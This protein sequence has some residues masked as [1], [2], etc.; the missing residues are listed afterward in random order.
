MATLVHSSGT[1]VRDYHTTQV[2]PNSVRKKQWPFATRKEELSVPNP[3]LETILSTREYLCDSLY[4]VFLWPV[5]DRPLYLL[6][7]IAEALRTPSFSPYIGRKSCP[8]ALPLHPQVVSAPDLHA[9]LSA[10]VFPDRGLLYRIPR[11]DTGMLFWEGS[12]DTG[13]EIRS[14]QTV[15]RRD[16]AL[17]RRQWTFSKRM[18]HSAMVAIPEGLQ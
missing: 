14:R 9:A 10:A 1:L 18:E 7:D 6:E 17:N 15:P 11:P 4:T 8:L 2:P 3:S 5:V 16:V 12:A 13:F